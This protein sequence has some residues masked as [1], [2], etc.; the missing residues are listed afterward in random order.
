MA[1]PASARAAGSDYLV[2]GRTIT[3]AADP[4]E[5]LARV[6]EALIN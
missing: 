1:T 6:R 4:V 2:V 5:A 3:R